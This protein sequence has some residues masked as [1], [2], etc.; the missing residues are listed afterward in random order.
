MCGVNISHRL[1]VCEYVGRKFHPLFST[2]LPSRCVHPLVGFEPVSKRISRD[3]PQSLWKLYF[4]TPVSFVIVGGSLLVYTLV[5]AYAKHITYTHIFQANI[6][7]KSNKTNK[8]E[9]H[10]VEHNNDRF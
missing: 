8:H 9:A 10:V 7:E 6:V 5:T 2:M 1:S 3:M 4:S